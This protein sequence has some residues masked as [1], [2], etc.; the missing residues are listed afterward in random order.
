MSDELDEQPRVREQT[1][2]QREQ[3]KLRLS[4]MP[5]LYH[6][7]R[8]SGRPHLGW[9]DEWQADVQERLMRLERVSFGRGCFLAESARIFGEP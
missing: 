4:Y 5:Y 8:R 6:E 3:H 1:P 7:Q 2:E 9:V